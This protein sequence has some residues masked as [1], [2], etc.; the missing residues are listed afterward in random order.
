MPTVLIMYTISFF[1]RANIAMAL[2]YITKDLGLTPVEVMR[3]WR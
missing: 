1:D 3:V 2:P